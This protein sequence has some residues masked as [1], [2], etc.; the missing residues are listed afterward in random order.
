MNMNHPI[1][2]TN[3]KENNVD[4]N[5]AT[6]KDER[7]RLEKGK[8]CAREHPLDNHVECDNDMSSSSTTNAM[9][10]NEESTNNNNENDNAS[11]F[12]VGDNSPNYEIKQTFYP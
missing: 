1:E 8:R 12:L 3:Y 7:L 2:K 4:N 10:N 6:I 5:N 9:P 11:S